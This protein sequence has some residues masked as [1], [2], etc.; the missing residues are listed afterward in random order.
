[1]RARLL[2]VAL[3]V[4]AFGYLSAQ[5]AGDEAVHPEDRAAVSPMRSTAAP[6]P[7]STFV[8]CMLTETGAPGDLGLSAEVM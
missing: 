4:F 5:A 1:M 3:T 8:E 7:R 6:L 2:G